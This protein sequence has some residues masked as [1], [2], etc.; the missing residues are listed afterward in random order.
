MQ[1]TKSIHF[2]QQDKILYKLRSFMYLGKICL[3]KIL[4]EKPKQCWSIEKLKGWGQGQCHSKL[5]VS[6]YNSILTKSRPYYSIFRKCVLLWV[7]L[8]QFS[9]NSNLFTHMHITV[10]TL[11]FHHS[12]GFL[13][14]H[15]WRLEI[16]IFTFIFFTFFTFKL[17][18]LMQFN[19]NLKKKHQM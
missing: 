10:I 4:P 18:K 11:T 2:L 9:H 6:F 3:G 19:Q 5:W 16:I 8:Q 1:C 7:Y 14:S 13:Y 15:S 17:Y 12:I